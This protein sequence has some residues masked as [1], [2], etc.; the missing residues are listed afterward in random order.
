MPVTFND[1]DPFKPRYKY[2]WD[3]ITGELKQNP[4]RWGVVEAVVPVAETPG[5]AQAT[6]KKFRTGVIAGVEAGEYEVTTRGS[7]IYARY[8]GEEGTQAKQ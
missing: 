1:D 7:T 2:D 8:V 3:N 5:A 4:G 6:A